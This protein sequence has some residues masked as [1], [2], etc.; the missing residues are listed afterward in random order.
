MARHGTIN[1]S[2][3]ASILIIYCSC[4]CLL[5]THYS[6]YYG[7]TCPEQQWS[8]CT[9]TRD[10]I[11]AHMPTT[12]HI[13]HVHAYNE[14]YQTHAYNKE[15]YHTH[16]DDNDDDDDDNDDYDNVMARLRD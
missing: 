7:R 13:T 8:H 5:V 6:S 9:N 14:S 11:P 1:I 16:D 15:S 10:P 2:I 4:S 12:N 3:I